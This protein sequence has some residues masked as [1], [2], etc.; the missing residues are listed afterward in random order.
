MILFCVLGG[1]PAAFDADEE[2]ADEAQ[3]EGGGDEEHAVALG[4]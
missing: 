1:A 3:R 4:A 2:E